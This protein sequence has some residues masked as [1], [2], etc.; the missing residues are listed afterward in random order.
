MYAE[1]P[2]DWENSTRKFPSKLFVRISDAQLELLIQFSSTA[3]NCERQ[4][5]TLSRDASRLRHQNL[6]EPLDH[7]DKHGEITYLVAI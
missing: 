4:L 3:L 5:Q 1:L 7:L 6:T 2:I